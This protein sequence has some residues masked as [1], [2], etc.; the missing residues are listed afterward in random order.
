MMRTYY[1]EVNGNIDVNIEFIDGCASPFKCIRA[2]KRL[3]SRNMQC[4][5]AYF[6]ISHD[7]GKFD[8][9]GGAVDAC[10]QKMF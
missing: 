4:V 10:N 9:L 5:R 2:V 6:E 1:D 8:G 3:A 7:K